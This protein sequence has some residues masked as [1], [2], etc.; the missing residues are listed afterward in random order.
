M[1]QVEA[2]KYRPKMPHPIFAKKSID[3]KFKFVSVTPNYKLTNRLSF[4][5]LVAS[6]FQ[7]SRRTVTILRQLARTTLA[8]HPS[9]EIDQP[10]SLIWMD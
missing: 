9:S 8:V 5:M 4:I 10:T 7:K 2:I 3:P 1:T 6:M